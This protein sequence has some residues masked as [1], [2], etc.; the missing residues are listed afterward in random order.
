MNAPFGAEMH[1]SRLA[2]L[3]LAVALLVLRPLFG[4]AAETIAA[5]ALPL[6][7][8]LVL[9]ILSG[10]LTIKLVGRE[11]LLP[12]LALPAFSLSVLGEFAPGRLDHHSLQILLLLTMAWC[13][14]EALERPRFS[15]GA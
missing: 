13:A 7:W 4:G 12:A 8:L 14:L 11:G 10:R 9:L 15:I 1:W 5:Y 2:D 3:P 6:I